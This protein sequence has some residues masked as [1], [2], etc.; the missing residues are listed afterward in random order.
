MAAIA[1]L[2]LLLS[3]GFDQLQHPKLLLR[4]IRQRDSEPHTSRV[5]N[6]E[7]SPYQRAVRR[8]HRF[9]KMILRAARSMAHVDCFPIGTAH[10]AAIQLRLRRITA[11]PATEDAV[12][13]ILFT[14][15]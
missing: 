13:A 15:A 11:L 2:Y 6:S 10:W 7:A 3:L 12:R 5:E 1:V 14:P 9:V 4:D 8:I